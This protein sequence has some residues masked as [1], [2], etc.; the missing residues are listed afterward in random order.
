MEID[1]TGYV[2]NNR[3]KIISL[4]VQTASLNEFE[5]KSRNISDTAKHPVLVI[6]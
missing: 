2:R 6:R 5:F 3:G 4:A 1:I